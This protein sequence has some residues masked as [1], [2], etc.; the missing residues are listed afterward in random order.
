MC[1]VLEDAYSYV[2]SGQL[3]RQTINMI[4]ELGLNSLTEREHFGAINEQLLNDL[5]NASNSDDHCSKS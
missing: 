2:R 3:M 4:K 5:Q 1:D